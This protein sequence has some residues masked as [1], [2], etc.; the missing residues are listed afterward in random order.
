ML[1]STHISSGWNYRVRRLSGAAEQLGRVCCAQELAP[2]YCDAIVE[3]WQNRTGA[4]AVRANGKA[5]RR[6]AR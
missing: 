2:G 4:K 6:G 5:T 1:A 3:R